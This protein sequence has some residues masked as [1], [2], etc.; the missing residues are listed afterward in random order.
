M[1]RA[2]DR[3]HEEIQ[4]VAIGR[5]IMSIAQMQRHRT[6]HRVSI[7][8]TTRDSVCE[9]D[10]QTRLGDVVVERELAQLQHVAIVD[11]SPW[12]RDRDTIQHQFREADISSMIVSTGASMVEELERTS[13][14]GVSHVPH[15]EQVARHHVRLRKRRYGISATEYRRR[16]C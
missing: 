3:Q 14:S 5:A 1:Q 6:A 4:S 11:H 16:C 10:R 15:D 7:T 2:V 8:V 13:S 12:I 9:A